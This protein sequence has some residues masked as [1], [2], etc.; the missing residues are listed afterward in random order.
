MKIN[1]EIIKHMAKNN[2]CRVTDLIALSS[3][4]DPFYIGSPTDIKHAE[5]F[6]NLW[7]KFG[8]QSGVHLRRIHYRIV[9][10]ETPV[11]LPDG[12]SYEN[13]ED[14]WNKLTEASKKARYLGMV[15]SDAFVDRRNPDPY[16]YHHEIEEEYVIYPYTDEYSTLSIPKLP[17]IPDYKINGFEGEQPYHIELWC[18]K[19][20]MNDELIPLCQGYGLDLVTG[21]GEMSIT[22]VINTIKRIESIGKP[23][24]LFYISD[25]DPAGQSMPVAVARKLEYFLKN[26]DLNVDIQLYPI[27]LTLDQ[28]IKYRLPRTP[29][30][31]SERRRDSFETRFGSGAVELD[32]LE[33]LHPGLLK[34]I[35]KENIEQYYDNSLQNRVWEARSTLRN[36]LRNIHQNIID[37][38]QDKIN[39]ISQEYNELSSK[40]SGRFYYLRERQE[41]LWQASH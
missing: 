3:Q 19:S 16:I 27:V 6:T 31:K 4:N 20:T 29:I 5:W 21:L 11:L 1:R 37:D 14:S 35:I 26:K 34:W 25:F 39:E 2:G 28:V 40:F 10:Q 13:T 8:F 22:L 41:S 36:D 9:S 18:E 24:R 17:D 23:A 15:N 12:K 38:Y 7:D 33:A 30:K 32:A